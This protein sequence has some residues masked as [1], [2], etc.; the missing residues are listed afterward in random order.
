[1]FEVNCKEHSWALADYSVSGA[2][3][4]SDDDDGKDDGLK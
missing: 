4:L 2:S 1:M 3:E